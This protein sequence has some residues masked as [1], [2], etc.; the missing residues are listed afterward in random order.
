MYFGHTVKPIPHAQIQRLGRKIDI[1]HKKVRSF[2]FCQLFTGKFQHHS[3][4]PLPLRPGMHIQTADFPR[5][6]ANADDGVRR[7]GCAG[8]IAG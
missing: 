3:T 8:R 5:L 1:Q 6:V 4:D 7:T 2:V